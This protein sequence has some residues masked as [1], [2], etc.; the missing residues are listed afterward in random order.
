MKDRKRCKHEVRECL[1]TGDSLDCRLP[2][3]R[4][5][6]QTLHSGVALAIQESIAAV[7]YGAV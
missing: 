7:R 6:P 2:A 1:L 4:E 3:V 5:H